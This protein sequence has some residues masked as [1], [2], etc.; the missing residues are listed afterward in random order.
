MPVSI[1][2]TITDCLSHFDYEDAIILAEAYYAKTKTD[3]ALNLYA[4]S[5]MQANRLLDAYD[6][7]KRE[8]FER[9]GR[10]RF[11]FARCAFGLKKLDEADCALR[12]ESVSNNVQLYEGFDEATAGHAHVLFGKILS[13][14]NRLAQAKRQYGFAMTV[15]PLMW[16]AIRAYYQIGGEALQS[17]P[18]R[19]STRRGSVGASADKSVV[20]W[21][22]LMAEVQE[23]LSLFH[24]EEALSLLEHVPSIYQS[25]AFTLRIKGTILFE[26]SDNKRCAEVFCEL[27]RLY[28]TRI[29]GMENY[30]TALWQLQDNHRLSALATE[31]VNS[32]RESP[33]TW[34]VVGNLLSL[35]KQHESAIESFE[36]AIQMN[37][38]FAYAYSLL[39]HELT[40]LG[41]V[42]RAQEAFR[43]A[44]IHSPNDYRSLYGQ[45]QV[46]Y[47]TEEYLNAK[48]VLQKAVQINSRNTV[49]LC[50]LAL[51]EH[52]MN[53]N[54]EAMKHLNN[55]LKL[56]P[57]SVVCRFHKARILF[58]I[59]EYKQA[60]QE[61]NELKVLS[62]DEAHVFLFVGTCSQ[63][64]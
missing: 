44:T 54:T 61:L 6:L 58:D 41:N 1:E 52:A 59:K 51:V 43:Q 2:S 4:H 22:H 37:P 10:S 11:L 29:E 15:N 19:T 14:T 34:C 49:L 50:Q 56:D 47:K 63:K 8:G 12:Q 17:L 26:L 35:Q 27:R 53:N 3:E 30:S 16:S 21:I 31:L 60:E 25:L 38:R 32:H 48:A 18:K 5:L 7:L 55:A 45:G 28:P 64:A 33:I 40:G 20:E 39:G 42:Q 36:R 24:C 62:P 13:E 9:T 57:N 23:Q 46:Y